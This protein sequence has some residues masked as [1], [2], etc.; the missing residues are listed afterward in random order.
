MCIAAAAGQVLRLKVIYMIVVEC[1]SRVEI[2]SEDF[3]LKQAS[4]AAAVCTY[5]Y[6]HQYMCF[7]VDVGGRSVIIRGGLYDSMG[8]LL[9]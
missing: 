5:T 8:A 9:W 7:L 2:T 1:C 4:G 3:H 6:T